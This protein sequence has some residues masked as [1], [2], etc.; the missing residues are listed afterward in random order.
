MGKQMGSAFAT[1]IRIQRALDLLEE[2]CVAAHCPCAV[3]WRARRALR[4][5]CA[6]LDESE[7]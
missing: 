6:V 1:S 5:L 4:P 7:V 3:R 2:T